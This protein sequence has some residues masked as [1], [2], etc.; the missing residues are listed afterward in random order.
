M[1]STNT[2]IENYI[3]K[4]YKGRFL[5]CFY[6]DCLPKLL[7]PNASL[8]ANYSNMGQEGTHWVALGN[9]NQ[10]NGKPS[11]Y[12]DS[13]G[14]AP[15]GADNILNKKTFFLDYIKKNSRNRFT[16]NKANL[17]APTADTC[18][19][20]ATFAICQQCV[21]HMEHPDPW[22]SFLQYHSTPESNDILIR[23]LINFS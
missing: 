7:P 19:E 4:H 13:F 2:Q 12:F 21:P 18:G 17:Q 3:K 23:K 16:N 11:F 20:Y 22:K 10:D 5:G 1:G 15:D 8:I 14:R 6:A 9:L